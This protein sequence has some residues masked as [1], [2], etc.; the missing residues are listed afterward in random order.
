LEFSKDGRLLALRE[1]D[2]VV[3]IWEN[4]FATLEQKLEGPLGTIEWLQWHP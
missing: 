2:G 4:S 1:M 3:N